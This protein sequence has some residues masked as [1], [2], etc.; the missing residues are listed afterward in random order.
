LKIKSVCRMPITWQ[1]LDD[2]RFQ[3]DPNV[4]WSVRDLCQTIQSIVDRQAADIVP[5]T[6]PLLTHQ[7]V[8]FDSRGVS[9]H[10]NHISLSKATEYPPLHVADPSGTSKTSPS[11]NSSQPSRGCII[12][13]PSPSPSPSSSAAMRSTPPSTSP[14]PGR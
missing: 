13:A 1:V 9:G 11:S 7:V 12:L 10:R 3:D 14:P 8:T 2:Q 6:H 4:S 5:H